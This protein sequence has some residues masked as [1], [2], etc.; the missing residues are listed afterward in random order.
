MS[1]GS[2]AMTTANHMIGKWF[3]QSDADSRRQET[4]Q[5]QGIIFHQSRIKERS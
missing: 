2:V 4:M 5:R 3:R 1:R